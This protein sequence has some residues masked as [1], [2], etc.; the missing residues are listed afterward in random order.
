M[1]YQ[2]DCHAWLAIR[3]VDNGA[4]GMVSRNWNAPV[5]WITWHVH[6]RESIFSSLCMGVSIVKDKDM[7]LI[8]ILLSQNV[9]CLSSL[10]KHITIREITI[11]VLSRFESNT[12]ITAI[13][14]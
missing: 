3:L 7:L 10:C 8:W 1:W 5:L 12:S 14:P 4:I 9:H 6:S 13:T 11:P 2:P